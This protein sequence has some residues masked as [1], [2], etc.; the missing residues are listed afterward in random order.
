MEEGDVPVVLL[1]LGRSQVQRSRR[2]GRELLALCGYGRDA[3]SPERSVSE[4]QLCVSETL[5][6]EDGSSH[7]SQPPQSSPNLSLALSI[8]LSLYIFS[9]GGGAVREGGRK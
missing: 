3:M 5:A 8:S 7:T 2:R 6:D 9:Q 1:L 4:D